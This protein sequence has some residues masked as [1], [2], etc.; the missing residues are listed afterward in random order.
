[1][2][3]VS[4]GF[5]GDFCPMARMEEAYLS[6]KWKQAFQEVLPFFLKN[7]LNIIDLEAPL[8]KQDKGIVKT[9]PHIKSLPET[10]EILKYL[11][12]NLVVTANN[13]FKDFGWKGMESSYKAL[14]ENSIE[15]FGSG[16]NIEEAS[17]TKVI[18]I[19]GLRFGIINMTENEWSTT[20]NDQPGCN[21]I[22]YP[23]ALNKIQE[24]KAEGCDF[25]IIVLHGGH[26]HYPLPSPRMKA[27]FRFMIDAGADAV[28]G[29]HTHIISGFEVYKNKPIF[30]SLGNFCF[31]W[32]GIRSSN[33]NKGLIVRLIFKQDSDIK[34]EFEFVHQNDQHIG[35]KKVDNGNEEILQ[36]EILRL[37]AIIKDD[38][39]LESHFQDY[40]KSLKPI[41]LSRIQPYRNKYLMSIHKRGILPDII[42]FS[43]KKMIKILTQ[44]ESHREVLLVSLEDIK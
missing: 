43:K 13:H 10:A 25:V 29:H 8:T 20:H 21:P 31:D 30:Y 11:N 9:G 28:I 14:N 5:T 35:V 36:K 6:G 12:C 1:M 38:E 17:K 27:Q 23:R 24:A 26:E 44:C 42:G 18:S 16:K 34:F 7:D 2:D 41:M 15:W 40:A 3:I 19:K 33:W 22:D 39:L 37:N 32:P 4:I